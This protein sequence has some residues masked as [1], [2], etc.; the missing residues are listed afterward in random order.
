[1]FASKQ[2]RGFFSV[3][4]HG[5]N[6]PP[7]VVEITPDYHAELFE[8][9]ARGLVIEWGDDGFP[10]LSEPPPPPPLT[11]EEVQALR[12]AAYRA[13]SDPLKVEAEYDALLS[14]EAPDY[15]AWQAS[16]AE[17]KERYPLPDE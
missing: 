3:A 14:G 5:D 1:M 17:I 11:R 8:G 2:A 7:D 9:Q 12:L 10:F 4:I 15:S 6:M 16:V 13:E